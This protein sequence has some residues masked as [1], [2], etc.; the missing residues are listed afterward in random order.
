MER[1]RILLIA[2]PGE[3]RGAY[4]QVLQGFDVECDVAESLHDVVREHSKVK[5]SGFLI[6]IPT[7]LRSSAA[8]KAEANLLSD[9]FPVMRLSHKSAD[10]IRCIPTGKFSGHGSTLAEFFKESCQNFTA[11]SLRGTK[12]ANKV[13]NVLLNRDINSKNS[14]MEKSVALNFSEEGCFLYSVS[15]WRKGDTL[16]I[17]IMELNDKTPIKSEV[18]WA[19]PWGV[20]SQMPGIGVNFLSLSEDQ[21]DQIEAIIRAKKV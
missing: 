1:I 9:N 5:Y 18:Q 15:R 12:R 6:D 17:A 16:W 10:G 19:V 7:L 2:A 13:L 14:H 4:L 20:K 3:S 8:D 11:R 21:A